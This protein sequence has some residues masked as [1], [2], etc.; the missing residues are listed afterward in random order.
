MVPDEVVDAAI[1]GS[2]PAVYSWRCWVT[3]W[4]VASSWA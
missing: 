3:G 1:R 2:T 4:M